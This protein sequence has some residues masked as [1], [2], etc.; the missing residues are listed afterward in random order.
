MTEQEIKKI[1]IDELSRQQ[2]FRDLS[3]LAVVSFAI[4]MIFA[5][6]KTTSEK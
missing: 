6:L 3:P 2:A 4:D 1:V 5:I